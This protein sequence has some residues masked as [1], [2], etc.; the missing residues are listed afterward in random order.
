MCAAVYFL[1]MGY[2]CVAVWVRACVCVLVCS[3]TPSS[4]PQANVVA[5]FA[6]V[7]FSSRVHDTHADPERVR[8]AAAWLIQTQWRISKARRPQAEAA[9]VDMLQAIPPIDPDAVPPQPVPLLR[10]EV[11]VCVCLR[12]ALVLPL[13]V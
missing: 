6:S 13:S 5:A 2:V 8:S 10:H 12:W 3:D 9:V 7:S 1:R 4:P 11:C